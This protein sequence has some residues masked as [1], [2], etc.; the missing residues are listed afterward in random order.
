VEHAKPD[1]DADEMLQTYLDLLVPIVAASFPTHVRD[2]MAARRQEDSRIVQE[3]RDTTGEARY[4]LRVTAPAHQID[5]ARDRRA[6]YKRAL[7]AFF[8][9][10]Y[11][12]I[13]SPVTPV[14]AFAHDHSVPMNAR[15]LNVDGREVPYMSALNWIATATALHA[16]ALVLPAARHKGLPIGIQL[17][18]PERG[19]RRLF[20]VALA[21]EQAIG[22]FPPPVL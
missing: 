15:S 9:Q 8:G 22:P 18:G 20:E 10:G 7:D 13:L 12:A 19:E 5:K 21:A 6:A 11:D 16:P 17:I 14:P 2:A 3:G 1:F 4:R